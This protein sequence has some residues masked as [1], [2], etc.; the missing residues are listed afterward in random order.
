MKVEDKM[1]DK[2]WDKFLEWLYKTHQITK[3]W[4]PDRISIEFFLEFSKGRGQ[5]E[6]NIHR[7]PI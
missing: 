2:E 1:I 3:D 6:A 4:T 7:K 5:N